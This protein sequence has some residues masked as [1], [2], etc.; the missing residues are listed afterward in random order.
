MKGSGCPAARGPGGCLFSWEL[1]LACH[2]RPGE[3]GGHGSLPGGHHSEA[4]SGRATTSDRHELWSGK[5]D[6]APQGPLP[7]P[8]L[9]AR[10]PRAASYRCGGGR[11]CSGNA[12]A[13]SASLARAAGCRRVPSRLRKAPVGRGPP[14][15]LPCRPGRLRSS[16]PRRLTASFSYTAFKPPAVAPA[17]PRLHLCF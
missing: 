17:T 16:S 12:Q 8:A 9:P 11:G 1:R 2:S 4:P 6:D 13:S 14:L 3:R 7:R 10:A 5:G 15:P